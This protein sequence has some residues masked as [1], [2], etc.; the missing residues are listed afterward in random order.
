MKTNNMRAIQLM[1]FATLALS[2]AIG[3]SDENNP[4]PNITHA[5]A[6]ALPQISGPPPGALTYTDETSPEAESALGLIG[7]LFHMECHDGQEGGTN[8]CPTGLATDSTL[9]ADSI[10]AQIQGSE[11]SLKDI[12]L[13]EE[14]E[15][16]TC[17]RGRNGQELAA[18]GQAVYSPAGSDRFILASRNTLHCVAEG[19]I[20]AAYVSLAYAK[21]EEG[22]KYALVSTY[23]DT[24]DN[25][26]QPRISDLGQVYLRMNGEKPEIMALN[27]AYYMED[28][29][30]NSSA[31]RTLLI[32][33]MVQHKFVI[34]QRADQNK[35]VGAGTAGYDDGGNY[36]DGTSVMRI[37]DPSNGIPTPLTF[38]LDNSPTAS[39]TDAV[40]DCDILGENFIDAP[41]GSWEAL[42]SFLNLTEDEDQDAL[43]GF[44][45]LF[46][47]GGFIPDDELPSSL[48]D[49][50]PSAIAAE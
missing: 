41:S 13:S 12:Y 19:E 42:S 18:N 27:L 7:K 46:D 24:S 44:S 16:L 49:G 15:H 28:S 6:K 2:I 43:I 4:F 11:F 8:F 25:G 37:V 26:G 17:T 31:A 9:F 45:R 39:P 14:N 20:D 1:G 48:S 22:R 10:I 36:Y 47:N 30:G 38:C 35:I 3:C 34:K 23:R 21:A 40:T 32:I 5:A 50:F 33:N 29:E